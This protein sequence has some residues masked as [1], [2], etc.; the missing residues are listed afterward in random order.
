MVE[1]FD[2]DKEYSFA[3]A[4]GRL[5]RY[6]R[7]YR[8]RLLAGLLAGSVTAG[9]MLPIY[10]VVQPVIRNMY[11]V[12]EIVPAAHAAHTD[13]AVKPPSA[14][15]RLDTNL[16]SL[17]AN[18]ANPR[19]A[20]TGKLPAWFDRMEAVGNRFGLSFRDEEGRMTGELLLIAL[21]VVPLVML[22][23]MTALYLNHYFLRWTGAKV[24]QDFRI[25]LFSHLQKQSLGFFGKVDVG[26]L[27]SRCTSDPHQVDNV[28]AHTLADLCRAPFEILFSIGFVIY[29]AIRNNMIETLVLVLVGFPLVLFPMAV[30]GSWV[31]RWSRRSLLRISYV[32]SKIHE[33]L[34]CI[35]V[36]KAYHTEAYE[37]EKYRK[38]NHFYMKSVLRAVRIELLITPAV[39]C[40]AIFLCFAFIT[41]CYFRRLTIDQI[42][43]LLVP[44][45]VAYRPMKQLGKVQ[46]QLERGRAALARMYSLLDLD[47][48]LPM[49][50]RPVRKE[51]F[52]DAVRFDHVGF[53]YGDG[54]DLTIRDLS[55]VLPRGSLVAVVGGTGSGKT[56]VANLLAR[57]YDPVS[58][59]VT[60]DGVDLRQIE[61]GDLRKL[62]GVVTQETVLFNDTIE[63]NIRYG[64][65]GTTREQVVAAAQMANA[66]T[67]ITDH[68]EGYDRVV[69]EKGFVLS[70]G[71]R[72]RVA[73]ARAILKNP[74]ILILDEATSALDTVTERLVQ[75]A[76][77]RLMA[78]RTT[79]AIAHRLSTIRN[80]DQ[81]LVME[82][83]AV[84][85]RGTHEELWAAGNKYRAL[86]DMQMME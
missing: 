45:L 59:S 58:G 2:F 1:S 52:E 66:H 19:A 40:V 23:K 33:N 38:A 22:V 8:F 31:R 84:I 11:S 57:F 36:V 72:Q 37:I 24:V 71:E 18:R 30:L 4:Y 78:N 7:K 42:A 6:A 86:C 12:E 16:K 61:I 21:V 10:Q 46:A 70:G 25:E 60:M 79:F 5:Y 51:Q 34:T 73:I 43:P 63:N 69:G 32:V 64:M 26:Q 54:P 77:N 35:R 81:I 68:P 15:Q 75:D 41:Y 29:F 85:E 76:I 55:F 65:P 44:I 14:P 13:D 62:I 50:A 39:E 28:I 82:K 53:R 27:I 20:A 48:S 67:F 56:T 3:E 74:P 80:A 47:M 9:S 17:V 49:A 83:G